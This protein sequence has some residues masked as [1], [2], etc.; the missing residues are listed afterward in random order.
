[1]C[2]PCSECHGRLELPDVEHLCIIVVYLSCFVSFEN[3]ASWPRND[4][5]AS[6]WPHAMANGWHG[7][8]WAIIALES[9]PDVSDHLRG[10]RVQAA[11]HETG[12]YVPKQLPIEDVGSRACCV[13][14]I[15][16]CCSIPS[17]PDLQLPPIHAKSSSLF[18]RQRT[19]TSHHI[20]F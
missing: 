20:E 6:A 12:S 2:L 17:R 1:M 13:A 19:P 9:S 4:A 3:E 11:A 14:V 7:P 5:V 10:Q 15:N 16:A 18:H 8:G